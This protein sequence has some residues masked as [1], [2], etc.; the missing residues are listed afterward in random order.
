VEDLKIDPEFESRL[1]PLSVEEFEQL[2]ENI[3]SQKVCFSPIVVWNGYDIILDGHN[4]YKICKKHGIERYEII[5]K[6]LSDRQAALEWI[7]KNQLGRRNLS[8]DQLSLI[9]GRLYNQRKLNP[10]DNLKKYQNEPSG[11]NVSSK[12]L[13]TAQQ[14]ARETGV[15]VNTIKRDGKFAERVDRDDELR[16][17]VM[18]KEMVRKIEIVLKDEEDWEK[19]LRKFCLKWK[20]VKEL[21]GVFEKAREIFG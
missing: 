16:E 9:R 5:E 2:E 8:P 1:V 6:S 4:R 14:I 18:K 17:K 13:T 15:S 19:E 12:G 11:E 21:E 7:D 20:D 10:I 3:V